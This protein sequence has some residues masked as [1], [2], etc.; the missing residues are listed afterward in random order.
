MDENPTDVVRIDVPTF[1]R[2]LEL[3]REDIEHDP[4]LHF[5]AQKVTELSQD[6]VVTMRDYQNIIKFMKN[7]G[8]DELA[9][10]KRLGGMQ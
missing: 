5:I 10:I 7:K 3:A 1:L 2:L 9:T 4:D 8:E 6:N